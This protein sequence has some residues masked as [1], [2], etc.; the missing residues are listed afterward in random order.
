MQDCICSD[1]PK[2]GPPQSGVIASAQKNDVK[3]FLSVKC[4]GEYSKKPMIANC[5]PTK[6]WRMVLDGL[7]TDDEIA[8][9]T[10]LVEKDTLVYGGGSGA[11]SILELYR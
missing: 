9:L 1:I 10:N 6:C 2:Y 8:T 4:S 7:L 3:H 5:S 11:A